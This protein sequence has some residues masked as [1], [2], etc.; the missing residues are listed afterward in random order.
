MQERSYK[1]GD[2][3]RKLMESTNEF[4]PK[5]GDGVRSQEQ[6]D[7]KKAYSDIEKETK[8]YNGGLT[9]EDK[10]SAYTACVKMEQPMLQ[11][12]GVKVEDDE[13]KAYFDEMWTW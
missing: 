2:L 6:T 4:N 12:G 7:S 13:V 10:V 8:A 11:A 5:F 3:K 9:E 1:F